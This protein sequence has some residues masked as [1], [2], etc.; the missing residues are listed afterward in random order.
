MIATRR[1]VISALVGAVYIA[2]TL[3]L[4]PISYG[5]VQF[6]VSEALTVLPYY[7]PS[8]AWGLFVGCLISNIFSPTASI[9]DIVFGSL[10]TLLA[11]YITS[12]LKS[13]LLAPLPPVVINA[14]VIG[15]VL[16]YTTAPGAVMA[17]FPAIA[18]SV[19]VGQFV[20]CYA[21]GLPLLFALSKLKRIWQD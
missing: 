1:L 14:I 11:G 17:A 21:L 2:L 10:A 13:K 3:L 5:A 18:L 8:T 7:I 6:R 19:G 15:A 20:V 12:K 16:S 9:L 4:A